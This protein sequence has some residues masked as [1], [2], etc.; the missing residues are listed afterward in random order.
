MVKKNMSFKIEG[1]EVY[2]KYNEICNKIKE[3]LGGI[4]LGSEAIYDGQYMKTKVKTFSEVTIILFEG[5]RIPKE[6]VEYVRIPCISI[7]SVLKVD[8]KFYSQ[9]YLDQCKYK[10]KKR[11][12]KSFIDYEIDLDSD[13]ESSK[14][15][16]YMVHI[17]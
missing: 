16:I 10:M 3:L 5:N 7:D 8:K 9:V 2:L 15:D 11:E 17:F 12:M 13:Y 14:K 6:R 1:D 4:K